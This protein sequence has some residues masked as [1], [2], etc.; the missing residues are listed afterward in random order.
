MALM[1]RASCLSPLANTSKAIADNQPDAP[2]YT[3]K[4]TL[5]KFGFGLT[6]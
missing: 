6:Y 3:A 1:R 4:D 5:Y 2:G